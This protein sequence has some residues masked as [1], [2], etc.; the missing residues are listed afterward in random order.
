M[1]G[2]I[3]VMR[4]W[5]RH[6]AIFL[7]VGAVLQ[8][9]STPTPGQAGAQRAAPL[10]VTQDAPKRPHITGIDHVRL[11]VTDIAKSREF[12]SKLMGV[13]Q[14]GGMCLLEESDR[15]FAA[16][17]GR[18]QSIELEVTPPNGTRNWLAEIA[19][20]T[21]NLELLQSYLVA[22]GVNVTKI[23]K[24]LNPYDNKPLYAHFEVRDPEGTPISFIQRFVHPIDDFPPNT[25]L[26]VRM[27][28]AGFV[29]K[30][31]AAENRFYVDLLGFKLY[32]YGG[33]KDDG[34]DWYEIQVP[35]GSDWIEYM[36]NIPANADHKELGVQNHFSLGV[37]DIHHAAD[38]L[39]KNGL[40][41]FDGPEIG[42][43]GKWGLDAYDPDGTRVEVME[44]TPAKNPCC[45]PYT[46]PHPTP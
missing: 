28:H 42:R 6:S 33:F 21:D 1:Q 10:H 11:Y 20:A 4:I 30:D 38:Q 12:Y 25:L 7:A 32:W 31:M 40:A 36:L 15:C 3:G 34:L 23:A 8:F 2:F 29:V 41:K 16:G 14:G 19:F 27:I 37:K 17:W 13:R 46:A 9:A 44:F 24:R 45:H 22:H 5:T 26:Y 39:H 43:D 18:N 35:D